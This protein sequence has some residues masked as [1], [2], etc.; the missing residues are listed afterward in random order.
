MSTSITG[1]ERE[2]FEYFDLAFLGYNNKLTK[3][4]LGQFLRNNAE[5]IL[6]ADMAT[7]TAYFKDGTKI[8]GLI[9]VDD[10]RLGGYRFDQ[11]ILFDDDRWLIRFDREEDIRIIKVLTMFDSNVPEEFQ[12][13]EYEDI[14]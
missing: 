14:R 5:Q 2:P 10:R 13:L 3:Y 12:I 11:L 6:K 1:T 4:G 9:G 8:K 7:L